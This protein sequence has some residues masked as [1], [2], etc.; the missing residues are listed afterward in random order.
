MAGTGS[1]LLQPTKL[2]QSDDFM[3]SMALPGY[4]STGSITLAADLALGGTNSVFYVVPDGMTVEV[5][6]AGVTFTSAE[7]LDGSNK[8]SLGIT[9]ITWVNGTSFTRDKDIV[10]PTV[11]NANGTIGYTWSIARGTFAFDSDSTAVS[12]Q[13]AA[14]TVIAFELTGQAG[15][16][17]TLGGDVW[18]RL[19]YISKDTEAI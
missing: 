18:V 5:M 13:F 6:D 3:D 7:A 8:I 11:L 2:I 10:A 9:T 15:T 12:N 17:T 4:V 14:G 1:G 19:K 16:T